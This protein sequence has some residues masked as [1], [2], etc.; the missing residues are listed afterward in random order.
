MSISADEELQTLGLAALL[1]GSPCWRNG[2]AIR[3]RWALFSS[4]M[5]VAETPH[6][7]QV[8]RTF[9]GMRD[10]F[11]AVFFVDRH[12]HRS[13][14]IVGGSRIHRRGDAVRAD[15]AAAGDQHR[16]D[17]DRDAAE[18]RP[19]DRF[20]RARRSASFRSS[21][22]RWEWAPRSCRQ[23]SIPRGRRLAADYAGGAPATRRSQ[24]IA[25]QVLQRQPRWT[26]AWQAARIET[27]LERFK[28]EQKRSPLCSLV[29]SGL[30][31]SGSKCWP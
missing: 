11:S 22:R 3:W 4:G 21:L 7:H 1:F 12:G 26:A 6:R 28:R 25:E 24:A 20:S 16:F 17:S 9:A 13:A 23:S 31:R 27:G 14:R 18:R 2:R 15:G 29:E 5:I 30:S 19:A 10:V 8:E